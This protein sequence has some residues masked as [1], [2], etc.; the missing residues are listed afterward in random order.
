[1]LLESTVE[2]GNG[3]DG[4]KWLDL[5]MLALFDGRERDEGQWRDLLAVGGFEVERL[6]GGVIEAR[7]R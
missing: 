7:C 5:L 2:A 3:A 4:A 6:G 1:M